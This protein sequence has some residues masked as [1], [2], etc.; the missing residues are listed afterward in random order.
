LIDISHSKR[1]TRPQDD[2]T[3][4]QLGCALAGP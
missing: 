3:T 2:K 4:R 1:T